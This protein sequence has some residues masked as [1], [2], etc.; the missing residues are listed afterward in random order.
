[1]W[2]GVAI[3]PSRSGRSAPTPMPT[4]LRILP[5]AALILEWHHSLAAPDSILQTGSSGCF[6]F[7]L[8]N[9]PVRVSVQLATLHRG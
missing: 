1:M 5:N 3:W 2:Y 4:N 7:K 9:I 8:P 6:L